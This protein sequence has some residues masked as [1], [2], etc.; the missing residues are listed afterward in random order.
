M[1]FTL[2]HSLVHISV[3][4]YMEMF[5]NCSHSNND[6]ISGLGTRHSVA[7]YNSMQAEWQKHEMS[8]TTTQSCS[9][10]TH[11]VTALHDSSR[12][13]Y[14]YKLNNFAICYSIT[15]VYYT[16]THARACTRIYIYMCYIIDVYVYFCHSLTTEIS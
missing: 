8:L 5:G 4:A 16:Y 13:Y 9:F 10:M 1:K 14:M 2:I 11:T 6:F 15:G 12:Y 3:M 7:A